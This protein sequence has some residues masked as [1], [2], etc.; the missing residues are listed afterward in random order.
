WVWIGLCHWLILPAAFAQVAQSRNSADN[1]KEPGS[2]P[3]AKDV[4]PEGVLRTQPI[5]SSPAPGKSNPETKSGNS[6][7][8]RPG[9]A[10]FVRRN[11]ATEEDLRQQLRWVPE[12]GLR[13]QDF[14]PLLKAYEAD[15]QSVLQITGNVDFE[16]HILLSVRPDLG[17]L[18][19]RSGS[20]SR[21]GDRAAA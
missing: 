5:P 16:P 14:A 13:S 6:Q 8:K 19:I 15:F 21:I 7:A 10:A 1:Q 20:V 12:V 18:P 17:K 4:K 3:A 11:Q 9:R 2:S